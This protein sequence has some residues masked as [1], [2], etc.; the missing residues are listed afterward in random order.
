MVITV[1]RYLFDAEDR[2]IGH[3]DV[4]R[5]KHL[6]NGN[7]CVGCLKIRE[8]VLRVVPVQNRWVCECHQQISVWNVLYSVGFKYLGGEFCLIHLQKH[9]IGHRV[10]G[11][12]GIS[13]QIA[14][15]VRVQKNRG[16]VFQFIGCSA[17]ILRLKRNDLPGKRD[18][19]NRASPRH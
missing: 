10:Q 7:T 12:A 19:R 15:I 8:T 2:G 14:A 1:S 4:F 3:I 5:V 13:N 11:T 17:L 18:K 9:P 16:M 6:R